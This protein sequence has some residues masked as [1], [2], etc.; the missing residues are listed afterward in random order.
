MRGPRVRR[1]SGPFE[2]VERAV[3]GVVRRQAVVE[4]GGH[5]VARDLAVAAEARARASTVPVPGSFVSRPGRTIVQRSPESASARSASRLAS[6][7]GRIGLSASMS[8]VPI[9]RDDQEALDAE[10]LRGLDALDARRRGPA[11]AC[12]PRRCPGPAPAA[13]TIASAPPTCGRT[14]SDSRSHRTRARRLT[15]GRRRGRGCGS[16][17]ARCVRAGPAV[18]R[19]DGRSA[20]ALRRRG[21]PWFE[22]TSSG[23]RVRPRR[24]VATCC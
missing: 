5:V 11:S 18:S 12:A 21:R 19:G 24:I 14:S 23:Y 6:R 9:E 15:R 20:R 3:D 4:H 22:A 16:G 8:C 17:R 10:L 7:Y 1:A 13:N 2:Q